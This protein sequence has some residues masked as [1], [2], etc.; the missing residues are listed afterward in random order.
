MNNVLAIV[1]AIALALSVG[2][3]PVGAPEPEPS[4]SPVP[5]PTPS[6]VPTAWYQDADTDG[7][8]SSD[9]SVSAVAQ[10]DGY[11]E[12]DLDCDDDDF[13]IN[14]DGSETAD[15]IDEDCD[16][17]V[18]NGFKYVFVSSTTYTG[19]LGGLEGA[20]SIC[21]SLADASILPV[22]VYKAWLSSSVESAAD[23]LQH[24]SQYYVTADGNLVA[25]G[26]DDLTDG[27]IQS[28]INVFE[29][30]EAPHNCRYGNRCVVRTSTQ[31]N[32]DAVI[33]ASSVVLDCN[34]WTSGVGPTREECNSGCSYDI[35]QTSQYGLSDVLDY[36]WTSNPPYQREPCSFDSN[37]YCIQQ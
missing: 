23:R 11:V 14:P 21:Q 16:D 36:S 6:P 10:P 15:L 33:D 4:P 31:Y 30:G 9:V 34:G 22:G 2:C 19:D 1:V 7:Y 28:A 27:A 24:S 17:R 13:L 29:S 12:N 3:T 18:D 37:L 20:D 32:G 35:D 8:G 26:W 5:T 25:N